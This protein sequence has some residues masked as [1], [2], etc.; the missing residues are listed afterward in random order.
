M[1]KQTAL[2]GA[3]KKCQICSDNKLENILSLGH[4]AL[5]SSYL[6]KEE[7][8]KS[9]MTYPLNFCRCAKCG[10]LQ[11]D[12]I[13]EPQTAF[14]K[15]YPYQ[16]GMTNMLIKNFCSL[17]EL[18]IKNYK[19]KSD[20]LIV[21]IGS[22]DGTL[23][24]GFKKNGMRVLGV[25]PTNV[26]KIAIKNGIPTIQK[27]FNKEVAKNIVIKKGKAKIITMTNAFAHVNE[28]FD[29]LQGVKHL[30]SNK[31]VFVSE[32]QYLLNTIEKGAF[33]CI[34]HEHLRFYS[35]KPLAYL[36]SRAG[37]TLID[38][39][40]IPAAGGSIRAYAMKGKRTPGKRVVE[41][42]TAEKKAGLYDIK[43]LKK[44]SEQA[45]TAKYDLLSLLI[46]CK[47][48]GRIAAIGSSARSNILMGFAK[49]NKDILD[50]ICEKKGSPKIGL[51]TPGTHIPVIEEKQL[52]EDQPEYALIL[53]WHIGEEL[54]QKLRTQGYKGKF[55][56]PLPKPRIV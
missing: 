26:A 14:H 33:D 46:N 30:L 47:K 54:T 40:I 3:I 43:R 13:V 39:E 21:D 55:I 35:L 36:F 42:I 11:L 16:T 8:Q 15:A 1:K 10:L 12:Y 17:A 34:Y 49:I 6:S 56:I 22:N 4:Q 20:D 52:F 25:E 44:F 38:A 7:L 19:L 32:S 27:F 41:L 24:K 37:F 29:L 50:Y 48:K 9:E 51:F 23:L 28:L 53:A 5:V 31:G 45:K 18:L 2:I